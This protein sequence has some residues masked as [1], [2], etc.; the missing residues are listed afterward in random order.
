MDSNLLNG[1]PLFGELSPIQRVDLAALVQIRHVA[2]N[3]PLFWIGDP[4]VE[5]YIIQHGQVAISYP[6]ENGKEIRLATLGAG[7]FLGEISLLDGGPRTATARAN[8]EVTLLS[9]GRDDFHEFIRRYPGVAIQML[10]VLGRRQRQTVDKL[11]GIRN[12]NDVMQERMT[13]WSRFA[14]AT[15]ALAGSSKF[16]ITHVAGFSSWIIINLTLGRGHAI[17][18]APFSGLCLWVS[19]EA[20]FLSMF[21]MISQNIQ[22]QKDRIRTEL[23]Y[24]VALKM[25]L[26]IMQLHQRMD[27]L[28]EVIIDRLKDNDAITLMKS[29][30]DAMPGPAPVIN[31]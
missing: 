20:I 8:G 14:M 26:E 27:E 16:L 28:P 18:P 11:R 22:G 25:Q 31:G 21:I 10:T 24:Q 7:D 12:L 17:D 5:F 19:V 13:P 6:D 30:R 23:E 3:E 29:A 1:I 2:P 4:G 9:L 15:A